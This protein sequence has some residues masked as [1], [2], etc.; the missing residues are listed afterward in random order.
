MSIN[1]LRYPHYQ[2]TNW[3][4]LKDFTYISGLSGYTMG[5]VVKL[6]RRRGRRSRT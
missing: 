2:K 4:P 3:D 1:S 6:R 5:I